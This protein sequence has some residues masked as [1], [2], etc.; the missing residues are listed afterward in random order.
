MT[1]TTNTAAVETMRAAIGQLLNE[2]GERQWQ[3][4]RGVPHKSLEEAFDAIIERAA[5]AAPAQPT[6]TMKPLQWCDEREP[7]EDVHYHHVVAESPLGRIT[8][9]WKGWKKYDSRCVYVGGEYIDSGSTLEDAKKIAERHLRNV[10]EALT[11]AAQV[12]PAPAAPAQAGWCK[13]CNPDNCGGCATP[14]AIDYWKDGDAIHD[15]YLTSALEDVALLY[16]KYDELYRSSC[17]QAP[18]QAA[19]RNGAL[20]APAQPVAWALQWPDDSRLNL[21]TVFDTQLEATDYL[22]SCSDGVVVVPL[23]AAPQ[24]A[25][26]LAAKWQLVPRQLT[27]DMA[28]AAKFVDGRLS[29]FKYADA[30]RAMLYAAPQP[31]AQAA[32]VDAERWLDLLAE[33]RAA[34][35]QPA[36]AALCERLDAFIDAA[37]AAQKD[38]ND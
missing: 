34:L 12:V 29:V 15:D 22:K 17:G 23:Y 36:N 11:T 13:D 37:R 28:E 6:L 33:A 10:V 24:P 8:V 9:E 26:H 31:A 2:F 16:A 27:Q 20:A 4:G 7:N 32:P 19:P 1:N 25:A 14:A 5:L 30:Y 3:S 35:W 18:A 38:T 21:S